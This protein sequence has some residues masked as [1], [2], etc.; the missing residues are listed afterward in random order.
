MVIGQ[1]QA[2]AHERETFFEINIRPVLAGTC[3]K[4]HGGEKTSGKLRVDSRAS[5]VA[6]GESGPAIVPGNVEASLLI[7]ALRH[8]DEELSMPPD[9]ALPSATVQQFATWIKDGAYWPAPQAKSD[10]AFRTKQHWAFEAIA[11]PEPP[12]GAAWS[13]HPIDRFVDVARRENKLTAVELADKP[14]LARRLYFDLVGLP[15]TPEELDAFVGDKRADAYERLV[16]RLLASPRYGERWGR[17]W[18]D[19]VRYAD[20]AG[21]NAD[22]PVPEARL[23][24]DYI[25]DS[26]NADKPYDQFVREQVAGD[27]LAQSA[28]PEKYAECV[29]ATGFLALS[30]RY[31]TA[32]YDEW[33]LTLED[34]IDTTGRALLGLTLR[35]ARCHD[36]KF[37]PTTTEDYYALY[38]IYN[39]TQFPY[40]G[41]EEFASRAKARMHFA[42]LAAPAEA[43]KKWKAYKDRLAELRSKV[44]SDTR[45]ADTRE[46]LKKLEA[47]IESLTAEIVHLENQNQDT[48]ALR[49]KRKFVR[50]EKEEVSKNLLN[51]DS[52]EHREYKA[53][54]MAGGPADILAYAVSEGEPAD[55]RVQKAGNPDDAGPTARRGPPKFLSGGETFE[56]PK[57]ASGRLQLANWLTSPRNP[58]VARVMVN[59]IWQHHFGKGLV[60]TPSNFGLR[61][62]KPSHPELLDYLATQ[63]IRSGWSMKAMH[64]LMVTSKTYRLSSDAAPNALASDPANRWYWRFDERRLD[65]DAIRDAMLYVAGQLDERRPG[66][67]P[68]PAL[69]TWDFTQHV[70]FREV[71]PSKHRSVYLMT[72][73]IQ[74]HPY[75]ALFDGAD[76]NASTDVRTSSTVPLQALFLM[77]SHFVREQAEGLAGRL[78]AKSSVAAE[79]AAWGQRMA[80]GRAATSDEQRAAG[81]Y[82]A[83]ASAELAKAGVPADRVE[84]EAWTSYAKLLLTANRFLYVN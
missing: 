54:T 58:L 75:L 80:W 61:G 31:M 46:H 50:V 77:N 59:R 84:R 72:Q 67:H 14:T 23:Y 60:S 56:I 27:I 55:A 40:P 41:S 69:V 57:G 82:I 9:G 30:R 81:E 66:P 1:P 2:G 44:E 26:F 79:R 29:T 13:N 37:D 35:C 65:A 78:I 24:R 22:Y 5:L 10:W 48:T 19:L 33:Q 28:P 76:P 38:G 42:S 45:D 51:G 62:E 12:A 36:H 11:A 34:T 73:R 68:F 70:P 39:S 20:T 49:T 53:L 18:M 7:K 21:D 74:R 52:P 64:R 47:Q 43:K 17:H 6:G 8:D 25:I 16:D 71:Y 32:P 4:C 83:L 63:F 3:F 15:P